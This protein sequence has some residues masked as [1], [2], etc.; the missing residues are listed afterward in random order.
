MPAS[1]PDLLIALAR[2]R[3]EHPPQEVEA[4]PAGDELACR[5]V[6]GPAGR[7]GRSRP[8]PGA[9]G[10]GSG[11]VFGGA[12]A[13][14]PR[15][16]TSIVRATVHPWSTSPMRSSSGI[17][18][19]SKNSSQKSAPPLI[20][21]MTRR[22]TP[23][24]WTGTPNQVSPRCLG[25]LQFV[26]ARQSPMSARCAHELHTLAPFST[27][28]SPSRV[29]RVCTPARSDPATGSE[30]NWHH[31][32]SPAS[33]RGRCRRLKSSD[34]WASIT[35]AHT[36]NVVPPAMPK[37]GS[38]YPAPSSR[39]A[40]SCATERPWPPNSDR[41]RDTGEAGF[42]QPTLLRPLGVDLLLGELVH[43]AQ[44]GRR[45]DRALRLALDVVG[46]PRPGARSEL[47]DTD[48]GGR[49]HQASPSCAPSP[50]RRQIRSRCQTG[51]P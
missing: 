38:A 1:P 50:W 29:A 3:F 8:G 20:W 48:G 27:H 45:R 2:R 4:V 42:E 47:L 5:R 37:L 12:T 35:C 17:T 32:S 6:V 49:G 15:S 26:R 33:I 22:S 19:S 39:N 13:D 40:R 25:T 28:V 36:P 16:K 24:A 46:Q 31:S 18:T 21:R 30:K 10:P 51:S 7:L 23:G 41:P 9:R 34:A 44:R 43:P 14:P 11:G